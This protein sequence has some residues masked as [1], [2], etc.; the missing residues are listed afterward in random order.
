[1]MYWRVFHA[2]SLDAAVACASGDFDIVPPQ[3]WVNPCGPLEYTIEQ[4]IIQDYV[5]TN[6]WA[7]LCSDRLMRAIDS[8]R[9]DR[10]SIQWLP[11]SVSHLSLEA[12]SWHVLHFPEVSDVVSRRESVFHGSRVVKVVLDRGAV[13]G[14]NV[15]ADGPYGQAFC[16]SDSVRRS[17]EK[18]RCTGLNFSV[19]PM[20]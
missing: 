17:I 12:E 14:L 9:G 6:D 20:A 16:V 4:G 7:R 18:A 5:V 1:M 3:G 8:A 10:D 15:F 2:E 13:E 11:A 19:A